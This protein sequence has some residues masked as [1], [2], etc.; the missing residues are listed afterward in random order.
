VGH[1]SPAPPLLCGVVSLGISAMSARVPWAAAPDGHPRRGRVTRWTAR[2]SCATTFCTDFPG[3][4]TRWGPWAAWSRVRA[5]SWASRPALVR[6]AGTP[7]RRSAGVTKRRAASGARSAVRRKARGGPAVSP[8]PDRDR[9]A[10]FTRRAVAS[11]RQRR[12]TGRWR[13]G[14]AAATGGRYVTTQRWMVAWSTGTPRSSIRASP[15][16]SRTG[17][18]TDQRTPM[19]MIAGGHWAPGKRT[20]CVALPLACHH[21]SAHENLRQSPAASARGVSTNHLSSSAP[22]LRS[23]LLGLALAP[24]VGLASRLRAYPNRPDCLYVI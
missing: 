17:D 5:A 19:R 16:R 23:P 15:C 2:G 9:H 6:R 4:M 21:E 13:R 14:T 12:P 22:P 1:A 3:R 24:L 10:P 8:A 11:I 18:A 20:A 7:G